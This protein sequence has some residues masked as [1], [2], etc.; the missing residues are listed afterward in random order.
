MIEAFSLPLA[1]PLGTATGDIERREGFLV[2]YDHRGVRGVGEATVLPGWTE[3]LDD[4]ERALERALDAGAD[5]RHNRA[6]LT[7]NA[8]EVPAARCGFATALLD[9]DARADGIP[10]YQ[11]FDGDTRCDSVPVNATVGDGDVEETVEVAES[12]V[13]AGF[14]CLKLKVGARELDADVAR[15]RAVRDAV[16]PDV[17]LRR[18]RRLGPRDGQSSTVGVRIVRRRLRRTTA[19]GRRPVGAGRP[20]RWAG[21]HRR[22]RIAGR[23]PRGGRPRCGGR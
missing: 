18:Q 20:P 1:S 8:G 5:D 4:C 3:S 23:V 10:F 13:D 16:G 22:R 7:M 2:G 6:L 12:A 14:D 17:T 19:P 15:L 9:A 21:R 11:W